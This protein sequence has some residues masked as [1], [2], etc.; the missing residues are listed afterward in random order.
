M[1]FKYHYKYRL[2]VFSFY[3]SIL[4]FILL[5]LRDHLFIWFIE[6]SSKFVVIFEF[7]NKIDLL[8]KKNQY[9]N[10]SLDLGFS[11]YIFKNHS[12]VETPILSE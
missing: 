1:K 7:S 11:L 12:V 2:S 8:L 9:Q 5:R 6:K 3:D 10:R 4:M